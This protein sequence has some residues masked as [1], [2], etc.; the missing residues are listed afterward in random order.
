MPKLVKRG[1]TYKPEKLKASIMKAGAS[2]ET[3]NEIV[4]STKVTEGMPTLMLRKQVL[5]KL[6]FLD[7][8]AA[9]RYET[10]RKA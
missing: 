2:E 1:D 9:E 4:E 7:S 6:R 10:Y 3:A 8:K 5:E